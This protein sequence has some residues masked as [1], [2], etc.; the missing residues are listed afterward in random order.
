MTS[1][2][3]IRLFHAASSE[4]TEQAALDVLRS[5]QIAGGPRVDEFQNRIAEL[6]GRPHVVCTSDVT[7]AL[8][9]ALRLAG[10]GPGDE[11]LTLA[12]SCMSSNAAITLVGATPVWV[13]IEPATASMSVKDL[14]RAI[15]PRSKAVTMYHV[16]GYPGEAA[17]VAAVCQQHGLAFIEDC[18]NALGA[19]QSGAPVG[20]FGDYAV[21][22]FYPNRQVNA[23]EG[24]A[25]VCPDAE[26]AA[27]VN[28][29]RR[30][31]ID[32]RTFRDAL[33]EISP[34]SDIPEI[35][36][37]APFNHLN[38]AVGLSQLPELA[39]RLAHTRDVAARLQR[40]L[41][42]VP[43]VQA[44]RATEGSDPAYWVLLLLA[45]QRDALLAALKRRRIDCSKLHLRNDLYSGFGASRRPLPGTDRLMAQVIAV[46][47]G[48][49][50]DGD[51]VDAL[52]AAIRDEA[53]A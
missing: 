52:A 44:V 23:V 14:E 30:F 17:L 24:G 4:A 21:Y 5:G 28:R 33:G 18:N 42:G 20:R 27:R 41:M 11:V 2:K 3:P 46:P 16:A 29:L 22:S 32:I 37:S 38:A 6:V 36:W 1:P 47:C 35:G 12:Y 34:A 48:W 50:L 51:Q 9:L 13:D 31:G 10:V 49:W 26:S 53:Q 8:V 25:L 7:H 43:G 19:M 45:Q 15:T 40:Q 39:A